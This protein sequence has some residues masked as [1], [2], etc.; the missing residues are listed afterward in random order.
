MTIVKVLPLPS[1]NASRHK[2]VTNMNNLV[3]PIYSAIEV[4]KPKEQK[5]NLL[6]R[7]RTI[8]WTPKNWGNIKKQKVTLLNS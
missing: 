4:H 5:L 8:S 7:I 3:F 1:E 6:L 2:K